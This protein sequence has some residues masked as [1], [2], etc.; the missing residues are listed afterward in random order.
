MPMCIYNPTFKKKII[1]FVSASNPLDKSCVDDIKGSVPLNNEEYINL[2]LRIIDS[3][4][5]NFD[6]LWVPLEYILTWKLGKNM[7]LNLMIT[8]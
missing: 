4:R 1:G 5:K 6:G 2:V 3:S 7:Q 8:A